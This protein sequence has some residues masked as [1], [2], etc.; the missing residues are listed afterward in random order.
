M[1][2]LVERRRV[3]SAAK[4]S[5]GDTSPLRGDVFKDCW[6]FVKVKVFNSQGPG[7]QGFLTSVG[8]YTPADEGQW[9]KLVLV[10]ELFQNNSINIKKKSLLR[11]SRPIQP[12]K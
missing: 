4:G 2:G 5:K 11:R 1:W 7:G 12:T 10:L 3:S 9:P 8:G 6:G